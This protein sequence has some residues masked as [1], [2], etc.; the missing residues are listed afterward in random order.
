M[1]AVGGSVISISFNGR[2]FSAPT[3]ADYARK[4]GGFEN[5]LQSNGDG[6]GRIIKTRVPGL[7]SGIV[8]A[9]DDSQSDQEF[10]QQIADSN[11]L[12][13][14]VVEFA[15]GEVYTGQ[16]IIIGE[17]TKASNPTTAAFDFAVQGKLVK[18]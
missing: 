9:I 16:G 3:D 18:Q 8:V 5:D 10:L 11:I 13:Q 17:L 4:L 15:D 6:T 1:T 7:L 12:S 14:V 2:Q